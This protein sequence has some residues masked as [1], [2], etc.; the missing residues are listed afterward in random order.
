MPQETNLNVS[1]YF[2][3]FDP[4]KNYY[5]VLFK[6]GYPVQ[7]RELNTV[8]SIFQNQVEQFGTHIFK[9]G[10]KVLGGN[11]SYNRN[12]KGVILEN[13]YLG[14]NV[15]DILVYL[16][17]NVVRGATSGVRAVVDHYITSDES[18]I[19]K[20]TIYL[21]YLSSGQNTDT[22][23]DG[24]VLEAEDNIETYSLEDEEDITFTGIEPNPIQSGQGIAVTVSENSNFIAAGVFLEDGV[25]FARG[26][27]VN[28]SKSFLLLEQYNNIP[29]YK[30]GLKVIEETVN[31]YEDITLNDNAQ[32]FSNYAAPGADRFKISLFLSSIPVDTTTNSSFILLKEIINGEEVTSKNTTA[33]NIL[34]EEFARRTY[35][36]SGDYYVKAPTI[37]ARETL[38]DLISNDGVFNEN[39][40]TY[41]NNTP[42]D[43]LGT[44][45]IS[46]L[47]AYISGFEVET[48]STI[49][50]DFP[51][52]RTTKT[53]QNQSINYVTGPT[54]TLN[55]VFGLPLI[56]L[57]TSYTL[58]LR[59]SR[60]GT[61]QVAASGKEIGLARVYDFALESGSYSISSANS[62]Q[63]DIALY[64]IQPYS[65]ISLNEP[66]TL[67]TPTHIKGKSSGATA[68]LRFDAS[69]SGILTAYNTQGKFS[70][71][72][73]LIFD[74]IENN[75][76]SIAVTN[77]STNDVKSLYG[78][79][80][81][82]YTFTADV[83]QKNN[84]TIGAVN[85]TAID[86][87]SGISTVTSS[88]IPFIGIAT[89]GNLV[90][91]TNP[92]N[93][94]I[95][96]AE[97]VSVS[98]NTLTISG[99]TTV[100]GVCEGALPTSEIN[101]T[102]FSLLSSSL[103]S[104]TDNTLYTQL[105]NSFVSSV[106]LT[107]S[108]LTIRKQF[109]VTIS[110]NS[111][112]TITAG[113]DE[114]FLPYDEE[115]YVLIRRDG[116]TEIL[117]PDKFTFTSGSRELTIDGLSGNGP[118]KL[119]ATLRKINVKSKV[120]KYNRVKTIIVDKSKYEGSGIGG[121][122]LNNGLVYGNY[123]YGT[124]VEDE[125]ICLLYPD[126]TKVHGIFESEDVANPDLPSM[127]FTTLSGPTNKTGDL[128]LGEKI[129]GS[130]SKA[131]AL[132]SEK[133]NDLKVGFVYLNNSSFF[134]GE[135]VTFEESGIT[136]TLAILD[137][138][139]SNITA[140]YSFEPS[141]KNTIYDY[142][143][144]VRN[145][146]SREP[147]K[148]IKIVFD[149][150][151]F[152][153]SDDGDITTA[154]SYDQFDYCDIGSINGIR[155]SDI[156]DIRQRVSNYSVSEGSR[157]PF[158]F[159]ARS[160][161]SGNSASNVLASD[162]SF[163][164]DYD[165]Y[166][167]RIDKIYLNKD[168]TF[169]LVLGDPS[170]NPK[171]PYAIQDALELATASLP[172]Y[173]C[174]VNDISFTFAEYKRYRMSDIKKLENRIKNLEYYT[175]LTLL[176]TDTHNLKIKDANGLDRFKCGIFV[177]NFTTTLYQKKITSVKNSI[178][179]AN[180]ELRP[181]HHTTSVDLILGSNSLIGI[182]TTANPRV[183]L[184][185]VNDL[186]GNNV[187]K[188]GQL[189]TLDYEEVTQLQQNFATRVVNVA[190]F[191]SNYYGGSVELF[192]SSDVWVNQNRM[193]AK[194]VEAEGNYTETSIQL[195]KQGF[196]LQ[197]GF[198]PVTWNSWETVW[199]GDT[200]TETTTKER[201]QGY[202]VYEDTIEATT[203]TGVS[204]R[205]GSGE[206]L[207]KQYDNTSF[208]DQVL[209]SQLI[210]FMRSRNIQFSAKRLKPFTQVYPFFDNVSMEDY[211]VP[212]LIE[213]Q[214]VS[215]V[216]EVGETVEVST[217]IR[218]NPYVKGKFRVAVNDHKYG[219]YDAPTTVFT[220]NPYEQ[221]VVLP[222]T[223]S[224]TS[225]VLNI[226][227]YSLANSPQ[228]EFYGYIASGAK[229][230]GQTSGAEAV[231]TNVRLFTDA[232]GSL[233]GCLHI[234]PGSNGGIQNGDVVLM[235]FDPNNYGPKFECGTKLFRLSSDDSNSEIPGATITSAEEK[236]FAEGKLNTVQ[237]NIISVR[238]AKV[239]TQTQTETK[240]ESETSEVVV[241][242]KLIRNKTPRVIRAGGDT[243]VGATTIYYNYGNAP[244]RSP[245]ASELKGYMQAA[246]FTGGAIKAGMSKA[247]QNKAVSKFNSSSY[248]KNNGIKISSSNTGTTRSGGGGKKSDMLLK[249]NITNINNALNRLMNINF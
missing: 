104:S 139:D 97:I 102:D 79:V 179:I 65:E 231:V 157:S 1:P 4:L 170:E 12:I 154:S 227:T 24:E 6:P 168:G 57:S 70:I 184:R 136:A 229:L 182:G 76:I 156:I 29:N 67:S 208:G 15:D 2:D 187:R 9:E 205:T 150:A 93:A 171:A 21:S 178:D 247:A 38:D 13:N 151:S 85:I 111:T 118:A 64:D 148:K 109:D 115:R 62:N 123:A 165:F 25:Y 43:D 201:T 11:L 112:G 216:F 244:L 68:F 91:F 34:S 163:S 100:S 185:F 228:G 84:F 122:T 188:T 144:I 175:S 59:D 177:D 82:A 75:R 237:E 22:F 206:V 189:I 108:N 87:P 114:T 248:A 69:N 26:T 214:M 3:D 199:S 240:Q 145:P 246:G 215:G 202:K 37:S 173:L 60:V 234:P 126:V 164:I 95:N 226:D 92:G 183:D 242:S 106:D 138:G 107:N 71:G 45:S 197:T 134:E 218:T 207:L 80:G 120:K 200:T 132:Y 50:L 153:E 161:T 194:V 73:K 224:A 66:I 238:N 236:F 204:T 96:F 195:E 196:D 5:K 129:I 14:I 51:K 141:H 53:L 47:K 223:Y 10:S 147:S 211:V 81:S 113:V 86:S 121:T 61:S 169:Q 101:P 89:A 105:P 18:V 46:P 249:K 117:T 233:L 40:K 220:Q 198:G 191:S 180:S 235:V 181:T 103:Q 23:I 44:Y 186:V 166:L 63:W 16:L 28:V 17:G 143:R 58:S 19:N 174:N 131:V 155:M 140:N 213:I 127:I 232:V 167:P 217:S 39:Q 48:V 203:K 172:P 8:Q 222:E 31:S 77:Y 32:G 52:P 7:A 209:D 110:S 36:E 135:T 33:Y 128:L 225:T 99:V 130:S 41:N 245:G 239:E 125:E 158:E 90:S 221:D 42:S 219:P 119:I 162:E 243:K 193:S 159:L 149:Y 56:G 72:E 146:E 27:F 78:I 152:S 176:E 241:D 55:R 88:T 20:P 133:I 230:I 142:S 83:T 116:T 212:K 210:P 54:Y 192:P 190:P 94:D 49:F 124:R 160:F 35:D 98:D 137:D 30:V 74:G